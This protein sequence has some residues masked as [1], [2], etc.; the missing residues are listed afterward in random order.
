MLWLWPKYALSSSAS[1]RVPKVWHV[2]NWQL[3]EAANSELLLLPIQEPQK[4]GT[5]CSA[6][7]SSFSLYNMVNYR[8]AECMGGKMAPETS[9]GGGW[10]IF[11]FLNYVWFEMLFVNHSNVFFNQ[12]VTLSNNNLSWRSSNSITWEK[13]L[14]HKKIKSACLWFMI[15]LWFMFVEYNW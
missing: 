7:H 10:F 13:C 6:M 1:Q 3:C 5:C 12:V 9:P 4:C 15:K 2:D 8:V 11:S 14:I